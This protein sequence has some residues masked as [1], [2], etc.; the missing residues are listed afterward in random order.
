M[1]ALFLVRGNVKHWCC[2]S[3]ELQ[4]TSLVAAQT[5]KD[6]TTA[7]CAIGG[8]ARRDPTFTPSSCAEAKDRV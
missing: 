4:N 6:Q 7:N 8:K 5:A 3:I 1:R 2:F